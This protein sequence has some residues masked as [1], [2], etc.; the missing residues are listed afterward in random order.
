MK[1]GNVFVRGKFTDSLS[2]E[3]LLWLKEQGGLPGRPGQRSAMPQV[4][5]PGARP[6][7]S[8]SL[9]AVLPGLGPCRFYPR[10]AGAGT[11]R[12]GA[13]AGAP[14]AAA[15]A[16]GRGGVPRGPGG[17]GRGAARRVGDGAAA[18]EPPRR[19]R[20]PGPVL[21]AER[22]RAAAGAAP[23]AQERPGLPPL[24]PGHLRPGRGPPGGAPLRAGQ[25]LLPGRRGGEPR[26][27]CGPQH[28]RQ[29]PP[30]R[31]LG[32]GRYLPDR[33]RPQ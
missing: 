25:L 15:A 6:G 2:Q 27:P 24:H 26:L 28:L 10:S 23:A 32:G 11:G 17:P 20:R 4:P 18:A 21:L 29:G 13:A 31:A 5:F 1:A 19:R 9:E 33:A 30:R 22:G 8:W 16:A 3:P 14:A 12:D 7:G